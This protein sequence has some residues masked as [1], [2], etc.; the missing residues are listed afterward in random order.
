MRR[1]SVLK[2]EKSEPRKREV[3]EERARERDRER[4]EGSLM[5]RIYLRASVSFLCR[6]S[7]E[8]VL[9]CSLSLSLGY[10]VAFDD[11]HFVLLPPPVDWISPGL[12]T[13]LLLFSHFRRVDERGQI[14]ASPGRVLRAPPLVR[15]DRRRQQISDDFDDSDSS[16]DHR[17]TEPSGGRAVANPM[18]ARARQIRSCRRADFARVT[19]HRSAAALSTAQ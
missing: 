16:D 12:P 14:A 7:G 13:F 17:T 19:H 8:K 10:L 1:A 18:H 11:G 2:R 15:S 5:N 6:A 9:S 3:A 4:E